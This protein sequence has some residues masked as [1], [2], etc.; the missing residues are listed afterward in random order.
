MGEQRNLTEENLEEL[1]AQFRKTQHNN[2]KIEHRLFGEDKQEDT[3][4]AVDTITIVKEIRC[5][6][7]SSERKIDLIMGSLKK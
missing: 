3:G 2:T 7:D 1:K 5:K 6:I 4:D